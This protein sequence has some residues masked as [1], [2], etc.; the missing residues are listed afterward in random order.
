MVVIINNDGPK[1]LHCFSK[2]TLPHASS[3]SNA[4]S[5]LLSALPGLHL[6]RHEEFQR[7]REALLDGDIVTAQER[8]GRMPTTPDGFVGSFEYAA[9]LH[10]EFGGGS[11]SGGG[12]G[13]GAGA[14]RQEG[15]GQRERV[16]GGYIRH[17]HL[18]NGTGETLC[19]KLLIMLKDIRPM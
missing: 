8:A 4:T 6:R 12:A 9:E 2:R 17:L 11:T 18:N 5:P 15:G 19:K 16:V 7:A 10:L 1:H 13:S 3:S 14:P